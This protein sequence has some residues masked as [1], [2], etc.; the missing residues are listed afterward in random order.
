MN[1]KFTS[2]GISILSIG[3]SFAQQP[4]QHSTRGVVATRERAAIGRKVGALRAGPA[5]N[6]AASPQASAPPP[7]P[8]VVQVFVSNGNVFATFIATS[9]IPAGAALGGS[10]SSDN[11]SQITFDNVSY[12]SAFAPGDYLQL[13]QFS[14]VGDVFPQGTLTYTVDVTINKQLTESNGQFLL[15]SPPVFNDLKSMKPVLYTTSQSIAAN[16]DMMLA[17]KGLFT[18]DTPLIVLGSFD[19]S[20]NFVVPASAIKSVTT[21]EIVVDLSHVPGGLDLSSLYEYELTVSQAGFADTLLYRYVPAAPKTFAH[22]S[23]HRTTP[24]TANSA[25]RSP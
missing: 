7:A 12:N 6:A 18:A 17:I 2:I 14:N 4:A 10:I 22:L 1:K 15:A 24:Q 11:G 20:T 5:R 13:P 8:G 16:G 23:K 9:V 25:Y 19:L 21:N 3:I